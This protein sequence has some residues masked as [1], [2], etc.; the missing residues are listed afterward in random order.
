MAA[1]RGWPL[2]GLLAALSSPLERDYR[3]LELRFGASP[4]IRALYTLLLHYAVITYE[5]VF[6]Q[7]ISSV[8]ELRVHL[9]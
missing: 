4:V 1:A 8:V 5:N 7:C 9:L 3:P 2:A 6:G